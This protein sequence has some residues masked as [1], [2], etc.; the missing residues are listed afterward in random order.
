MV[1]NHV[2][3]HAR[4]IV[5]TASPF[6]ADRFGIGDLNVIDIAAVPDRLEDAVGKAKHQKVLNR[7]LA[8]IVIDSEDLV[9]GEHGCDLL[10]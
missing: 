1:L 8:E 9:F 10:V 6:H 7:L 2:A 3:K 4:G 5:V